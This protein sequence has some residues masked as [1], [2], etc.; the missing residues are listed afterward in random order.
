MKNKNGIRK[1]RKSRV[2]LGTFCCFEFEYSEALFEGP[3]KNFKTQNKRTIKKN[4]KNIKYKKK[5]NCCLSL[6]YNLS[7]IYFN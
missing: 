1:V 6:L 3:N 7:S 4:L 5:R 2:S